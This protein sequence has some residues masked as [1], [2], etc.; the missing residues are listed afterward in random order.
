V[1]SMRIEFVAR[2]GGFGGGRAAPPVSVTGPAAHQYKIETSLDGK[3]YTT[4]LD[5]TANQVS[6][7][8]EFEELSPTRC[9]FVRLTMTGWPHMANSP[10]GIM[11]FTVFGTPI[12]GK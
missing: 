4:V 10:L 3:S 2:G 6:K 5:K 1:D 11:E 9:R 8:T 7:Y 12:E